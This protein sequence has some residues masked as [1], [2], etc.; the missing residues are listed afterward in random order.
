[1]LTIFTIPKPFDGHIG[2]IQRNAIKSW[3]LLSPS[4]EIILIGD[5][6]GVKETA[7]EANLRH[8]PTIAKNKFGTP[9]L[10][11]AFTLANK[12]ARFN[13]LLYM[14]CDVI[15]TQDLFGAIA[16][17]KGRTKPYA[18]IG[19]AWGLDI[20]FEL[21]F[22][23]NWEQ[24]LRSEA[25][26]KAKRRGANAIEYFLFTRGLWPDV[27]PFAVGRT[28]YDNWLMRQARKQSIPVIDAS[29][30]VLAIHQNHHYPKELSCKL[31]AEPNISRWSNPELKE[32]ERLLGLTYLFTTKHATHILSSNGVRR[33]WRRD[34]L[35]SRVMGRIMLILEKSVFMTLVFNFFIRQVRYIHTKLIQD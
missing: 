16:R 6:P 3:A 24:E 12:G 2:L 23:D 17:L 21:T 9:L 10:N 30:S 26:N 35:L 34:Y 11:D 27:P 20:D 25:R 18:M 5:E 8:L 19:G 33:V 29:D 32:N 22:G 1:M 14:N 4:V 13:L 7:C 28:R 15:L 31:S